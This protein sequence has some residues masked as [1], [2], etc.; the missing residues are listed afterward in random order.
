M[1]KSGKEQGPWT[2]DQMRG[3]YVQGFLQP[4]LPVRRE[5]ETTFTP[6]NA[7]NPPL[8]FTFQVAMPGF[9]PGGPSSRPMSAT[10]G[11]AARAPSSLVQLR[12]DGKEGY[13]VD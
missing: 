13:K 1:D 11:L 2:T 10:W 4:H 9:F 3:W 5:N 12:E 6:I 8:P 7:H